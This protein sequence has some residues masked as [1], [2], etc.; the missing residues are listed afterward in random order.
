MICSVHSTNNGAIVEDNTAAPESEQPA[1]LGPE[2]SSPLPF[3]F[4]FTGCCLYCLPSVS[5]SLNNSAVPRLLRILS[6]L[7]LGLLL[8]FRLLSSALTFTAGLA[9]VALTGN[10]GGR[11]I[12]PLPVPENRY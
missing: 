2:L 10:G 9:S 11:Y 6:G 12:L 3:L 5:F 1:M 8:Y 4:C 7:S